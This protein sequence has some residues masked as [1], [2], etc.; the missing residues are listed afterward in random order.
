MGRGHLCLE[1]GS[2]HK[3]MPEADV[4]LDR[5]LEYDGER[6]GVLKIDRRPMVIGDVCQL[7]F[8]DKVFSYIIC[9]HV[10]EHLPKP[11]DGFR[12][13]MRVGKAGYIETPSEFAERLEPHRAYHRWFVRRTQHGLLLV[14][15]GMITDWHLDK[16]FHH[17]WRDNFSYRLFYVLNPDVFLTRYEWQ[18]EIH[19]RV[20]DHFEQPL[21]QVFSVRESTWQFAVKAVKKAFDKGKRLY[22]QRVRCF[23]K[24]VDVWPLLACP[25]CHGEVERVEQ[26]VM[27]PACCLRYP[28]KGDIPIMLVEEAEAF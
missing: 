28:I 4:L 23:Q 24:P 6:G 10:V 11:G 3:P 20:V 8:K 14:P 13:M 21:D 15:R 7:P 26:S 1:I 18:Q 19:W 9:R 2:G 25:I 5:Y 22:Y 12:E 16:L 27:C 17:L